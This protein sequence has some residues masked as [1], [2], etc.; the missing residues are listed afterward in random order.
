MYLPVIIVAIL[1]LGLP[2]YGQEG[3]STQV[4]PDGWDQWMPDHGMFKLYLN[5]DCRTDDSLPRIDIL[6][7]D[8]SYPF[9]MQHISDTAF[10]TLMPPGVQLSERSTLEGLPE[11][12]SLVIRA[13][14]EQAV[15]TFSYDSG[16]VEINSLDSASFINVLQVQPLSPKIVYLSLPGTGNHA[17]TIKQ[18]LTRL[19]DMA[20]LVQM[21]DG[22]YRGIWRRVSQTT[23]R[24]WK[25]NEVG[26][27][28]TD[29]GTLL[30]FELASPDNRAPVEMIL[31]EY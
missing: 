21:E 12:F 29:T 6:C 28:T 13:G 1:T 30:F 4:L 16:E 10:L 24:T 11:K 19:N 14:T 26:A 23:I 5:T 27:G 7:K 9:S 22:Y 15:Y 2:V 31:D 25:L 17:K 3:S 8:G 18:V 20:S